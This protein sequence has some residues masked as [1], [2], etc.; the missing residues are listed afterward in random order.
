MA[1]RTTLAFEAHVI[2]H[3]R[4]QYSRPYGPRPRAVL[5]N[6]GIRKSIC[7]NRLEV[8]VKSSEVHGLLSNNLEI[9]LQPLL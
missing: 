8:E 5:N 2:G 1:Y 6:P 4:G 7:N 9:H 3:S